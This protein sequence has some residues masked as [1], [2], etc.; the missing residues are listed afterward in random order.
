M[1]R[2]LSLQT[3]SLA[4]AGVVLAGFLALA[5]VA[6]DRAFVEASESTLRDRL[7][8]YLYAY[9]AG[10]DTTRS[11]TLIPPEIGPDPRFDEPSA[12]GLYAGIVGEQILERHQCHSRGTGSRR[13]PSQ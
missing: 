6:L 11:G 7:Q 9:L 10:S 12:S 3:R 13:M 4:A 8:G 2:P 5:F 1:A